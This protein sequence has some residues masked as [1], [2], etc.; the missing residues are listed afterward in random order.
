M[1]QTILIFLLLIG[2]IVSISSKGFG[3]SL[4]LLTGLHPRPQSSYFLGSAP[5]A[6]IN[7]NWHI[8][9]DVFARDQGTM[10]AIANLQRNLRSIVGDTLGLIAYDSTVPG[11]RPNSLVII[12]GETNS[13]FI[14]S[15]LSQLPIDDSLLRLESYSLDVNTIANRILIAGADTNGTFDAVATLIQLIQGS[16]NSIPP[17]HIYDWTDYPIRWVFSGH[18]LIEASQIDSLKKIEDTMAAHKLNGLQQNDFKNNVYSV[19]EGSYPQ[20]FHNVDSLQAYS[21][22]SNVEIIPGVFPFGWSEGILFHD[23]DIAEGIPTTTSYLIQS[24]TG[25]LLTDPNMVLPNGGFE[26]V[27]N[28]QFTGWSWY[29]SPGT[30]IFVDSVTVYKGR[31]SARCTNQIGRAHV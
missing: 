15:E 3:Q 6:N 23:P 10:R 2:A 26:N 16:G 20:Y 31:Y 9:Y 14:R 30:N 22:K 17:L 27:S 12:V 5:Q 28:G 7:K 25:V 18:N 19:F 8:V 4:S 11:P 21:A 24:D 29:D 13:N 1:K